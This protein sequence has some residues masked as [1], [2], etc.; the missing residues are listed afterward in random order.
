MTPTTFSVYYSNS[1]NARRLSRSLLLPATVAPHGTTNSTGER[2]QYIAVRKTLSVSRE[3]SMLRYA[4]S[5]QFTRGI[6]ASLRAREIHGKRLRQT[7]RPQEIKNPRQERGVLEEPQ[8]PQFFLRLTLIAHISLDDLPTT[9]FSNRGHIVA[10]GP[11]PPSPQCTAV[12]VM[13]FTTP[14][15][16]SARRYFTGNTIW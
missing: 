7:L 2:G 10:I 9:T 16:S 12:S 11:K 14:S 13:I 15:S 4:E 5:S 8:L 1:R 6:L 3:V